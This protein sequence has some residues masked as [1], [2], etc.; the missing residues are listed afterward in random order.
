MA[1]DMF[2]CFV[3]NGKMNQNDKLMVNLL[4]PDVC[5][6]YPVFFFYGAFW[7]LALKVKLD[8][9]NFLTNMF[10]KLMPTLF[11]DEGN[12]HVSRSL[13]VLGLVIQSSSG[14]LFQTRS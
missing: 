2:F 8:K 12:K 6:K 11:N 10:S 13:I 3:I 1:A 7:A 4:A 9:D 14:F 5:R